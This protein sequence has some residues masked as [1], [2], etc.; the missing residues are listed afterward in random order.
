MQVCTLLQ[1]ENH[2]STPPLSFLQAGCPSC[3]PT[4]SVKA[5]KAYMVLH[6]QQWIHGGPEKVVQT[7]QLTSFICLWVHNFLFVFIVCVCVFKHISKLH[8]SCCINYL[9]L[10]R[11]IVWTTYYFILITCANRVQCLAL[12]VHTRHCLCVFF[13]QCSFLP[14]YLT[15]VVYRTVIVW[16]SVYL[17]QLWIY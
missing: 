4:N 6:A 13:L 14:W 15:V 8:T 16:H 9:Y 12:L 17:V 11:V 1:T 2:T 5:L 3:H 10:Y 7:V